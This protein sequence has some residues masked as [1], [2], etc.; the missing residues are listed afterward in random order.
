M[1]EPWL[2]SFCSGLHVY[3]P[4][5]YSWMA[6]V[7]PTCALCTM[8]HM[9]HFLYVR[10]S[11]RLD[12]TKNHWT[13]IHILKSIISPQYRGFFVVYF[14]FSYKASKEVFQYW[15]VGPSWVN[16]CQGGLIANVK[17]HFFW[18]RLTW[19][20]WLNGFCSGLDWPESHGWMVLFWI[21]L[22]V[23]WPIRQHWSRWIL[24]LQE[25]LFL[26]P[27]SLLGRPLQNIWNVKGY[28]T[29]V[30]CSS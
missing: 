7:E 16:A 17:L 29:I 18:I 8:A 6:F 13:I 27:V 24:W 15:N 23:D 12:W 3:Q 14:L 2:T 9:H 4:V 26:W 25:G 20:L 19:E 11:V 28:H 10:L 22:V 30:Q 21:Q 5:I 1:I